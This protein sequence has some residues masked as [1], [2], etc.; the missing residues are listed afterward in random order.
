MT[1]IQ[2]HSQCPQC[3][4]RAGV[5][6]YPCTEVW[7]ASQ[8]QVGT[9]CAKRDALAAQRA[10]ATETIWRVYEAIYGHRKAEGI[11]PWDTAAKGAAAVVAH[12]DALAARLAEAEREDKRLTAEVFRM[13]IELAEAERDAARYREVWNSWPLTFG[14]M[15]QNVYGIYPIENKAQ[16]DAAI[17]AAMERQP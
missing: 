14:E 7:T 8:M 13:S 4:G 1:T 5:H 15:L 10:E 16:G 12:R 17:D 9:G 3:G 11:D 6:Y 2:I